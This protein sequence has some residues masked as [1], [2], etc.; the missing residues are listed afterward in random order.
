[1]TTPSFADLVAPL[2]PHTF[3]ETHFDK[4]PLHLKEDSAVRRAVLSW[5]DFNA[6]LEALP[7]WT[8]TNLALF[9]NTR[10]VKRALYCG[11][12]GDPGRV[13]PLRVNSFLGMGASLIAEHADAVSPS[14]R[15]AAHALSAG[16][17][18][19]VTANVY[20]S[21]EGVQAFGSHHDLSEVFV[22]QTAGRKRWRIYEGREDAPVDPLPPGD[23]TVRWFESRKGALKSELTLE[24]GQALYLPRGQYHDAL[25]VDGPSLHVTFAVEP[26]TGLDVFD[27]LREAA[28]ADPAFR[29]WLPDGRE[30]GAAGLK[31]R[32]EELAHRL[33]ALAMNGR[34]VDALLAAQQELMAP[35]PHY[36]LPTIVDPDWRQVRRDRVRL[37][38]GED[39]DRLEAAIG[40]H[41]LGPASAAAAWILEQATVSM[42][43]LEARYGGL[44]DGALTALVSFL[45]SSGA[46]VR[47]G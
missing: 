46:L 1:M 35:P 22:V 38:R 36:A 34:V 30:E 2:D 26:M 20:C 3:L 41:A 23:A 15:R 27:L 12:G 31:A 40:M 11:F 45:T 43:L 7:Y 16:T 33:P 10:P 37:V 4:A 9:L 5:D 42:V 29:A 6:A 47:Q 14:V 39:G 8:G 44:P 25:A 24:A 19:R 18:A 13:D 28:K 32:I 21:F 17:G